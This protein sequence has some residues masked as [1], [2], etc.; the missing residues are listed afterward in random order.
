MKDDIDY[1]VNDFFPDPKDIGLA[2]GIIKGEQHH[3]FGYGK[4]KETSVEL[5][6]GNTLFEI[7]SVTKVFTT[8]L[9]SLLVAE[10]KL[11]L[12][13]S[14]RDLL[15]EIS[16]LPP[17]ITLE[18]LAT[19]TSG[20]PKMPSNVIGTMLRNRHNP[21]VKYPT[22]KLF[23]YLSNYKSKRELTPNIE[24][25]NLGVALLGHILEKKIGIP[26]EE[27][28]IKKVCDKLDMS[29]TRIT[30]NSEQKDRLATPHSA[31][32]KTSNNWDLPAFAGAGALRS[33]VNDLLKFLDAHIG[34]LDSVLKDSLKICHEKHP[35][36][37]SLPRRMLRIFPSL[38]QKR[39]EFDS[40]FQ[41]I[42]LGWIIGQIKK[43]GPKVYWHHGATGGYIAFTGFVKSS[44]TGIVI[45][46]NRG[47]HFSEGTNNISMVDEIGFKILELYNP[48]E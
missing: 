19:H 7:G 47:P 39:K 23:E 30:L 27:A 16:N 24:Y 10:E 9:L 48:S 12:D 38:I 1:I 20:L 43:D 2:I 37:F 33:T 13:D 28:I 46:A 45:L 29:D 15:P 14:V 4:A 21:Y 36:V 31:K 44:K 5:P 22:A 40:Y 35:G 8:T 18:R 17:E 32:G 6:N 11:N 25:S 41:E 34:G 26:Y 42:A 3:V